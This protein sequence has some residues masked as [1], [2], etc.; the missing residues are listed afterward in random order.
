[1]PWMDSYFESHFPPTHTPTHT[2]QLRIGSTTWSNYVI[3]ST[4]TYVYQCLYLWEVASGS[5]SPGRWWWAAQ[6]YAP[7][8]IA[9]RGAR[10]SQ[11]TL[12]AGLCL[13][14]L[15]VTYVELPAYVRELLACK[16]KQWCGWEVVPMQYRE[17]E[18]QEHMLLYTMSEL[19]LNGSSS[20]ALIC[21]CW[22]YT[23][24]PYRVH[25]TCCVV[26][27]TAS[28]ADTVPAARDTS[29]Y[30]SLPQSLQDQY[31]IAF[32]CNW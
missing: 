14:H 5:L 32:L 26:E 19:W 12:K 27:Y 23:T 9:W 13:I 4:T 21:I 18:A 20:Y 6:H 31:Q 2:H 17:T 25:A 1:M 10:V 7:C 29:T 15:P 16:V 28:Q 30:Q 22:E 11:H 3:Q 24:I 8:D